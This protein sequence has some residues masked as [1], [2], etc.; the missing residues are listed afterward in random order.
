MMPGTYWWRWDISLSTWKPFRQLDAYTHRRGNHAHLFLKRCTSFAQVMRIFCLKD[1]HQ[2]VKSCARFLLTRYAGFAHG[3]IRCHEFE[4]PWFVTKASLSRHMN[5]SCHLTSNC[6]FVMNS[7][8]LSFSIILI[9]VK[10]SQ[11]FDENRLYRKSKSRRAERYGV[12]GMVEIRS[13]KWH[14]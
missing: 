13:S 5:N 10:T 14:D 2:L 7:T 8:R 6:H 12:E 3:E 1:A 4:S 11:V 9:I